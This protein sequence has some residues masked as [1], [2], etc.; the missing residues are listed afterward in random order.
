MVKVDRYWRLL[1]LAETS[2]SHKNHKIPKLV[3]QLIDVGL[4]GVDSMNQKV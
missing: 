1:A 2:L 4:L 3:V